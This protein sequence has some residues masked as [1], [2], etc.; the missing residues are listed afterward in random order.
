MEWKKIKLE[1][2]LA[3]IFFLVH[4]I[5]SVILFNF[6]YKGEFNL[7]SLFAISFDFPLFIIYQKLVD[8]IVDNITFYKLYFIIGGSILYFIVGW[9]IGMLINS[10]KKN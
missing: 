4:L 1:K 3:I 9:I 2:K 6:Y 8:N 7:S 5:L 10:F